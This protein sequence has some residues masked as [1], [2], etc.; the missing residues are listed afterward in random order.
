MTY[1]LKGS[2]SKEHMHDRYQVVK[3]QVKLETGASSC[4]MVVLNRKRL[5]QG[6][7]I[8]A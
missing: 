8:M 4:D 5:M 3:E 7:R 1:Y 6:K 2:R